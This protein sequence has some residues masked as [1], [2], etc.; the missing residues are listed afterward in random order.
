MKAISCCFFPARVLLGCLRWFRSST[1]SLFNNKRSPF[2]LFVMIIQIRPGRL[3]YKDHLPLLQPTQSVNSPDTSPPTNHQVSKWNWLCFCWAVWWVFPVSSRT[4][5]GR[6]RWATVLP[7]TV[8]STLIS[9]FFPPSSSR[10]RHRIRRWLL[11]TTDWAPSRRLRVV[12]RPSSILSSGCFSS[13]TC[14]LTRE[15]WLQRWHLPSQ[16][17]SSTLVFKRDICKL[18]RRV[19]I[20]GNG[21][22]QKLLKSCRHRK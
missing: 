17:L 1:S 20:V 7:S 18:Q 9:T 6:L 14:C 4:G 8:T 11:W 15:R 2:G 12:C 19:P 21:K 16:L 5:C 22:F 10:S 3:I 13:G